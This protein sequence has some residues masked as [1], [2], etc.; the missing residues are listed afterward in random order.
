MALMTA[1]VALTLMCLGRTA[2]PVVASPT[3]GA[4]GDI[5]AD[6]LAAPA[7][8]DFVVVGGGTAGCAVAARLCEY[9]P[10]V[11]I[12]LLERGAPRNDAQELL[13]RS[14][15]FTGEAWREPAVAEAIVTEPNPGLAGRT[16]TTFTGR[17]LGGSSSINAGQWTKP[18]LA[19]F[20]HPQW[21]FTGARSPVSV[22]L[23][24]ATYPFPRRAAGTPHLLPQKLMT[25]P[26]TCRR[27][28]RLSISC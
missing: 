21:A 12:V 14:P 3:E 16:A 18:A 17:T 5:T 23:F 6:E 13:V 2:T 27:L 7:E 10:D 22:V 1:A 4:Y 20:D 11:S 24:I 9:L 26:A 25:L 8:A 28:C 15:R 19:T